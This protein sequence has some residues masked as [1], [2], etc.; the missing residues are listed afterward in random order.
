MNTPPADGSKIVFNLTIIKDSLFRQDSFLLILQLRRYSTVHCPGHSSAVL[1][2]F[3][4][5]GTVKH[6]NDMARLMADGQQIIVIMLCWL[7][8]LLLTL[9]FFRYFFP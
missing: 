1:V 7:Y 5:S 3:V 6:V 8:P 4:N 2:V 9:K